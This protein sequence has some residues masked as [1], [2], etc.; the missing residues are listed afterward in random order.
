M[1]RITIDYYIV[2]VFYLKKRF[3]VFSLVIQGYSGAESTHLERSSDIFWRKGSRLVWTGVQDKVVRKSAEENV[4]S[5][6][7]N[8]YYQ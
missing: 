4:N 5:V 3:Y 7:I 1:V 2:L 6:G 8:I